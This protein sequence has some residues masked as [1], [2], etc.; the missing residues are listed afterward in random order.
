MPDVWR[1]FHLLICGLWLTVNAEHWKSTWDV[2]ENFA[3]L[4][5]LIS[6]GMF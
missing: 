4:Q 1:P 6:D 3:T 2:E 5:S